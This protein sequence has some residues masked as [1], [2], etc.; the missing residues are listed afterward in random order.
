MG[1][2]L[3]ISCEDLAAIDVPTLVIQGSDSYVLDAMM[4]DEVVRCQPNA[5]TFVLDGANHGGP[6]QKSDD[7]IDAVLSF[8]ASTER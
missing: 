2:A 7:F 6:I 8:V 1:A 4:S 3:P 5:S